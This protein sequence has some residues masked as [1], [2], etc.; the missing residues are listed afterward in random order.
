M[1]E[2]ERH[3]KAVES[4]ARRQALETERACAER[5][6]KAM[7]LESRARGIAE[8]EAQRLIR[9]AESLKA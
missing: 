2:A 9:T 1:D 8:Q 7:E 5:E 4:D 3:A 6:R